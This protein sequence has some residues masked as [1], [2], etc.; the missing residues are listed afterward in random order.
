MRRSFTDANPP[1]TSDT[2]LSISGERT[3]TL[4]PFFFGSAF[5]LAGDEDAAAAD[6][7]DFPANSLALRADD[8]AP[9]GVLLEEDEEKEE[10]AGDEE[11]ATGLAL[12]GA[13]APPM[14]SCTAL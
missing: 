14:R 10:E 4:V 13:A 2:A 6:A 1:S 3:S 9:V 5:S 12:V 7:E 11:L 8:E